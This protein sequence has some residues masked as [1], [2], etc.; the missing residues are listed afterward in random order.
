VLGSRAAAHH[1]HSPDV[2][3]DLRLLSIEGLEV[4]DETQGDVLRS[5]F[6]EWHVHADSGAELD[7]NLFLAVKDFLTSQ[8]SIH[9]DQDCIEKY[10]F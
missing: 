7:K 8:R 4:E 3:K 6:S 5:F 1:L 9:N 2:L 10:D